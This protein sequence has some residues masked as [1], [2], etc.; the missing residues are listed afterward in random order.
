HPRPRGHAAGERPRAHRAGRRPA[1][2]VRG[3]GQAAEDRDPRRD[4]AVLP[5]LLTRR[6]ALADLGSREVAGRLRRSL[7]AADHLGPAAGQAGWRDGR[8]VRARVERAGEGSVLTS[9]GGPERAPQT[10]RTLGPPRRSRGA[11]RCPFTCPAFG[12]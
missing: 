10:P 1:G 11:P 3:G 7:D 4:R 5:A 9:M 6:E 12:G 8:A 2:T